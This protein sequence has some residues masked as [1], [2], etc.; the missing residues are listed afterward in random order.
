MTYRE[1]LPN[2]P[3]QSNFGRPEHTEVPADHFFEEEEHQ[4]PDQ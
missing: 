4:N 3:A 1:A 2:Q